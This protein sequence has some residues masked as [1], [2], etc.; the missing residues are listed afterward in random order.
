MYRNKRLTESAKH[1]E[2]VS[3]GNPQCCWAHSNLL[4]HGK[5]RGQK[6]HD[7]FG[8]Y[9]CLNCHD[10]FDGRSKI[11]PPSFQ[12]QSESKFAWFMRMNEK[13]LIVACD[14]GYI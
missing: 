3:C 4:I 9:L 7:I 1:E 12:C 14:K 8:A 5:G 6:A 13:S 10:W 2:C 11:Y